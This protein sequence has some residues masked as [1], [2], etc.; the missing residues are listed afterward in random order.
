MAEIILRIDG[1]HCG[2]CVKRVSQALG[3]APGL[4]VKE[5]R[6]GAAR[7]ESDQQSAAGQAVEAL[8]K[9]GYR[10]HLEEALAKN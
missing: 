9:A 4:A 1:M 6:I 10:A 5:V 8:A 2:A 7:I 3:A